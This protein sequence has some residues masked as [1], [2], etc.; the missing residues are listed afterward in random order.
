MKKPDPVQWGIDIR[1][2][3]QYLGHKSLETTLIYTHL[4]PL[5]KKGVSDKINNLMKDLI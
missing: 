2:I 3:S 1:I 4:T 5:I